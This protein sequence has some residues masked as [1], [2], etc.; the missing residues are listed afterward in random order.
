ME[1]YNVT[2]LDKRDS[3]DFEDWSVVSPPVQ[4]DTSGSLRAAEIVARRE[5]PQARLVGIPRPEGSRDAFFELEGM[6]LV[7]QVE[8]TNLLNPYQRKGL[9]V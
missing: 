7:L 1:R 5:D 3:I 9:R 8:D 2:V 4:V 6:D